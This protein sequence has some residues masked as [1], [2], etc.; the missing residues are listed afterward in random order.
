MR[1]ALTSKCFPKTKD[2]F[3]MPYSQCRVKWFRRKLLPNILQI[4]FQLRILNVEQSMPQ[5][6]FS[7]SKSPIIRTKCCWTPAKHRNGNLANLFASS[8]L[9]LKQL[10]LANYPRFSVDRTFHRIFFYPLSGP[11]HFLSA[12]EIVFYSSRAQKNAR[13]WNFFFFFG[14]R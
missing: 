10:L 1:S 7:F 12:A 6:F 5:F 13:R 3:L 2:N 14:W 8:F 11:E 9:L 4:F